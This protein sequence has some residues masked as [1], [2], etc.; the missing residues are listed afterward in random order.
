MSEANFEQSLNVSERKR[1]LFFGLPFTF[2]VYTLKNKSLILKEG[3][4]NTSENEILLYR[5]VDMTLN[6]TLFQR[7][8]GLGS[9]VLEAQDKTHPYL[10]IKNI[11]HSRNFRDLLA[12]AVENDKLRLRMRQGELIDS[13]ADGFDDLSCACEELHQH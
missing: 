3:F 6:R 2:T 8:F 1:W 12:N 7:I 10:E 13:Q 4:L 9:I 11:K 5:I